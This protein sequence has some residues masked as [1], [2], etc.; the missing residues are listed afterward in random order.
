MLA[1]KILR[2]A[3]WAALQTGNFTG[4]PVDIADGFIHLST[5][6]QLAETARRHFAGETGLMVLA[7]ELNLLGPTVKWE[8][9]RGGAMF[10][11]I[12]GPLTLDAVLAAEPL[13]WDGDEI[14]LPL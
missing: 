11:H 12:Y 8:P 14:R 9:S 2:A 10:P 1:F 3:E 6:A 7:T 4:A 13:T 5:A